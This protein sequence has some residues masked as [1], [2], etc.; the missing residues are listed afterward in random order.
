MLEEL[1]REVCEANLA[2][3]RHGLVILTWG[4]VSGIDRAQGLFV[5]KPSGIDY[6]RLTPDDM[7]IMDLQNLSWLNWLKWLRKDMI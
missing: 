7:I 6:D 4:N 1:K 3:V 5:I 2:L